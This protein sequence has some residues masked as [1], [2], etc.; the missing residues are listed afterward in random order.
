MKKFMFMALMLI[1]GISMKAED[2][3][4]IVPFTT[5]AGVI[6]D[7]AKTMM[8]SLTNDDAIVNIIYFELYLPKGLSLDLTYDVD[9]DENTAV[10]GFAAER[11]TYKSG[12][13]NASTNHTAA[14]NYLGE[15]NGYNK[16]LFLVTQGTT[17]VPIQGKSGDLF[18]VFYLTDENMAP[19]VYPIYLKAIE[20][21]ETEHEIM[22]QV[23]CVTSYV[24]IEGASASTLPVQGSIP[25]FVNEKLASETAISTLDLKDMTASYGTFTYVDGR[26]VIAPTEA[27]AGD[28][29]YT[30]AASETVSS[31][32][33]PF[34]VAD[35]T[36]YLPSSIEGEYAL[37]AAQTGL[38][39]G[40]S[41]LVDAGTAVSASAE[42]A[43]IGGVA[44]EVITDGYYLKGGSMYSVNGSATIPALRGY[45]TFDSPVKGF[46]LEGATGINAISTAIDADATIYNVAGQKLSKAQ[47]GVNIINGKKI[48]VK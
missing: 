46:I 37:F 31:I 4:A 21:T 32:K 41:A 15:E 9:G 42:D 6:S 1:C 22:V 29:A 12:R 38:A 24:V 27:V 11:T 7:D 8:F 10:N 14:Y 48:V 16:Y 34:A 17:I 18:D 45:F 19:G 35:G 40:T 2:Q 36:Y 25:S 43:T 30:R 20:L 3:I 33:L 47:K 28:V 23:P 26:D 13:N 44:K 5:Q 39:A